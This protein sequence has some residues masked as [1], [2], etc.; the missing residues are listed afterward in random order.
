M[1]RAR[2]LTVA[3]GGVRPL[4][5][6]DLDLGAAVHGVIGPNGAGKTTLLNVFSGFV[7]PERGSVDCDG[8]D[9]FALSARARARWGLRRTFQTEQLAD[10]LSAAANIQ[11]ALDGTPGRARHHRLEAQRVCE[12]LGLTRRDVPVATLDNSERRLTELGRAL[13]GSPKVVLLDEPGAGLSG[14]EVAR[15]RSVIEG[16]HPGTGAQT[17]V[18]DH[19]VELIAAVCSEVC[20]L[21]FGRLL[22][23]GP[24]DDVLRDDTVRA[25]YLGTLDVI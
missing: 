24:T 10:R 18:I 9:L 13:V 4:D 1:I 17:I 8:T 12:L 16:I 3:F 19:D 7:V 11:I 22:V 14:D 25:A 21:D 5:A 15:L 6:L 23:N 20:V 2:D